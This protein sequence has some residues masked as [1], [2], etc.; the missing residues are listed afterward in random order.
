MCVCIY[1]YLFIIFLLLGATP[2]A[3]RSSQA[4]GWIGTTAASLC[5]SHS[6]VGSEPCLWPTPQF[7]A[8]RIPN[9]VSEAG[10]SNLHALMPVGF[11]SPAPQWERQSICH[12]F[13]IHLFVDSHL[14]CLHILTIVNSAFL[15]IWMCYLF[16]LMFLFYW[17]IYT[18]VELVDCLVVLLLSFWGT[19][20]LFCIVAA[21]IY[22]LSNNVQGIPFHYILSNICYF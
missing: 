21:P 7:T 20:I 1:V 17:N 16:E 12:I 4:R 13:F 19:S 3:Y 6:N 10:G 8:T 11:T 9:P 22:I 15:N 14:G 2:M 5:H 18:G